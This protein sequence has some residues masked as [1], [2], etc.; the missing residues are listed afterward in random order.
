MAIVDFANSNLPDQARIEIEG[1]AT[2]LPTSWKVK[3]T[4]TSGYLQSLSVVVEGDHAR[5]ARDVESDR[6][7]LVSSFL[8][9]LA[10]AFVKRSE[11]QRGWPGAE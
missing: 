4:T 11:S 7:D 10:T 9:D 8:Q 2:Q 3:L 6:F 1:L 5:Y